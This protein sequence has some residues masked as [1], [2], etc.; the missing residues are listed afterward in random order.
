MALVKWATALTSTCVLFVSGLVP[1]SSLPSM[2][3]WV[4]RELADFSSFDGV[5][6]LPRPGAL[7][8]DP[9]VL[10]VMEG[11]DVPGVARVIAESFTNV[12]VRQSPTAAAWENA[13]INGVASLVNAYDVCARFNAHHDLLSSQVAEYSLGLRLR[14]GDRLL[15]PRDVQLADDPGSLVITVARCDAIHA[16]GAIELRL[17]SVDGTAP[18]PFLLLDK[19]RQG[20][21]PLLRRSFA[22]TRPYIS[23][24]CVSS[25]CRRRGIAGALLSA[26]EFVSGMVWGYDTVFLH[27]HRQND[28]ALRL[29]Q[30][31]GYIPISLEHTAAVAAAPSLIYHYKPLKP[32]APSAAQLKQRIHAYYA[33]AQLTTVDPTASKSGAPASH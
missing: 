18:G 1:L 2:K 6:L 3:A 16:V 19:L 13:A 10:G 29:Y 14:C 4:A 26:A 28:A 22:T 11:R 32:A 30:R 27:V 31:A 5:Y 33:S 23:N 25:C 20:T 17:R 12:V 9:L 7:D 24:L 21:P 15:R 8:P